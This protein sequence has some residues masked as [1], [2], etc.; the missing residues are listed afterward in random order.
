MKSETLLIT[1]VVL[2]V[3][4]AAVAGGSKKKLSTEEAYE[5]LSG[6]WMNEAYSEGE[7]GYKFV[8]Q[9]DGNYTGY[10][11]MS[12]ESEDITTSGIF[13]ILDTKIDSDGIIW[14]IARNDGEDYA[15]YTAYEIQKYSNA[16]MTME[17]FHSEIE[18][19]WGEGFPT[20]LKPE[21]QLKYAYRIFYRQ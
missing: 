14:I 4:T 5:I 9:P 8:V 6:T 16:N 19:W 17:V 21:D 15:K 12:A 13:T 2:L 10:P 1:T 11:S 3:A 20:D 18:D 7:R